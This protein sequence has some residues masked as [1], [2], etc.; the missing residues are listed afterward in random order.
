MIEILFTVCPKCEHIIKP[1]TKLKDHI[2]LKFYNCSKCG[3]PIKA[4]TH[5]HVC[6]DMP[7][8]GEL[9]EARKYKLYIF[10]HPQILKI[11]TKQAEITNFPHGAMFADCGYRMDAQGFAIL[12]CHPDFDPVPVG[13]SSPWIMA[14]W[15]DL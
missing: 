8:L 13:E 11:F 1:G 2:C 9:Y 15:K 14:E 3:E 12:V 7:T 6:K 4:A 5:D 10:E